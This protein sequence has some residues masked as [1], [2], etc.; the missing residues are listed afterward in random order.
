MIWVLGC[1]GSSEPA[2]SSPQAEP[3]ASRPLVLEAPSEGGHYRVRVRPASP[4]IALHT[5]HDWIVGIELA[6]GSGEVPTAV[7]FDG[8]MPSHGHGFVTRPR[9]TRNLGDGEFLVEGV[10]FHMPGEWVLQVTITSR[11]ASDYAT[12]PLLVDP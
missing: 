12:L 6:E 7:Q 9:V 1:E 4:P 2:G 11:G 5:M 8:G 3:D 10:K